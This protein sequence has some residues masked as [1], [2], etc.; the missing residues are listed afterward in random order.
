MTKQTHTI[1]CLKPE[2]DHLLHATRRF[3]CCDTFGRQTGTA[4][5]GCDTVNAVKIVSGQ[6]APVLWTRMANWKQADSVSSIWDQDWPF[7]N[8]GLTRACLNHCRTM[9]DDKD[10]FMTLVTMGIISSKQ[11]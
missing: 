11:S 9:P 4:L 3:Q 7:L 10:L 5:E 8:R 2:V 6:H 1:A